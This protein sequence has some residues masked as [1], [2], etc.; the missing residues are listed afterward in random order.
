MCRCQVYPNCKFWKSLPDSDDIRAGVKRAYEEFFV[1]VSKCQTSK[2]IWVARVLFPSKLNLLFDQGRI[3][4]Q[5][6]QPEKESFESWFC[7]GPV[8]HPVLVIFIPTNLPKM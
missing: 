8:V 3:L 7:I 5:H 6:K 2:N 1:Q 4:L